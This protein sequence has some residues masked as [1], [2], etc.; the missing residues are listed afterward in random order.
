[1]ATASPTSTRTSTTARQLENS[2]MRALVLLTF[3]MS[4]VE[5]STASLLILPVGTR[6]PS[7]KTT[8]TT[9]TTM[10]DLNKAKLKKVV[11]SHAWQAV[12]IFTHIRPQDTG[13]RA[14]HPAPL[15]KHGDPWY[16]WPDKSV[17]LVSVLKGVSTAHRSLLQSTSLLIY[18]STPLSSSSRARRNVL[19]WT[20]QR[21]SAQLLLHYILCRNCRS[22]CSLISVTLSA[23]RG[24]GAARSG[25]S[26]R[27]VTLL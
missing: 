26:T 8:S 17:W 9:R 18:S 22:A 16:P 7:L 2:M 5:F 21:N 1:M 27:S 14:Y 25:I 13:S 23:N 19:Y 11:S 15:A 3:V 20:G 12:V 6:I 24:L 10:M 4:L